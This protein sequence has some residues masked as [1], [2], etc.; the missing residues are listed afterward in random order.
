[1]HQT[2]TDDLARARLEDLKAIANKLSIEILFSDFSYSE[3]P[4][5]SGLCRVNQS[6]MIVLDRNLPAAGQVEVLLDIFR[7]F[8]LEDIYVASWVRER[9][10]NCEFTGTES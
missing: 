1:M 7:Q 5:R 6:Q 2:T 8:D 10:D 9:L 3:V 4:L